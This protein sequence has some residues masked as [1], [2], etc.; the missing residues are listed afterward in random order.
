MDCRWPPRLG[1]AMSA[2]RRPRR[3]AKKTTVQC[4]CGS[5]CAGGRAAC[6]DY[7]RSGWGLWCGNCGHRHGC[8]ASARV[9][10]GKKKT[11]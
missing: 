11:K 3:A 10:G 2:P 9:S 5:W 4:I 1:E 8:H 6:R 7:M